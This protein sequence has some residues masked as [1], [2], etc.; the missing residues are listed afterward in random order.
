MRRRNA[1]TDCDSDG[2]GADQPAIDQPATNQPGGDGY[3]HHD[4]R[5]NGD[6][7]AAANAF[8]AADA[9]TVLG[10]EPDRRNR[11]RQRSLRDGGA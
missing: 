4:S 9:V 2:S 7:F 1:A 8:A 6:A 5:R 10:C 3:C 11:G